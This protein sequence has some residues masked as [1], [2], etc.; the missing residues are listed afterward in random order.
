MKYLACETFF[1]GQCFSGELV[2]YLDNLIWEKIPLEYVVCDNT[3]IKKVR[4]DY[5]FN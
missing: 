3:S 4:N 1:D 5:T 2:F